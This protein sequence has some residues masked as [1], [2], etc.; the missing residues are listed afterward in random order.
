MNILLDAYFDCNYGDDIFIQGIASLFPAHKFYVFLEYY[1]E[2]I[3]QW[4]QS[5]PN[6]FPLPENAMFLEKG[7]FDAYL[8]VGGDVFPDGGNYEK[9]KRYIS[10]VKAVNGK[11]IF[12]GF[13]M[14]HSY[15]EETRKDL[16]DM[17]GE[18]DLIAPR[19]DAS[20]EILKEILGGREILSMADLA[21]ST[22]FLNPGADSENSANVANV[23]DS[24]N[25]A[26]VTNSAAASKKSILGISVRRPGNVTDE[27]MEGYIQGICDVI[28]TY[29]GTVR[30]YG[31]SDGVNTDTDLID[32]IMGRVKNPGRVE[33]IIYAGDI[34]GIVASME[35][36][37]LFIGTR[38]HA[39][40]TCIAK[41][42]P[43]IPVSYEVK[44]DHLFEE[45]SY[46]GTVVAFE[47]AA[48]LS[49]IIKNAQGKKYAEI[50]SCEEDT[51]AK[52][53]SKSKLILESVGA[54]LGIVNCEPVKK[55]GI[56][57]FDY[58]EAIYGKTQAVE[59]IHRQEESE[60]LAGYLKTIEELNAAQAEHFR[61]I[62]ELNKQNAEFNSL[63][64][65]LAGEKAE[66]EQTVAELKQ[67][68][69]E[70]EQTLA[71]LRARK[72]MDRVLNKEPEVPKPEG[73]GGGNNDGEQ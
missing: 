33:K 37:E 52:Y 24:S 62:D 8:C 19:D 5:I 23:T 22:E 7:L 30:L 57:A 44:T 32:E 41:K 61:M 10:A 49:K 71:A 67:T 64:A 70:L 73:N 29:T 2:K 42:I 40:L 35:E 54:L 17:L 26:S 53:A 4:A 16:R 72:L 38:F 36:C 47:N 59:E 55:E 13:N 18:A 60:A 50:F 25:T 34:E 14:F 65:K 15:G 66:L 39:I 28:D 21:L 27:V 63:A 51:V 6:V 9:R 58:T 45:I 68:V 20:A 56:G 43:F 46:R 48:E 11:V 12:V 69:A 3:V 1:P 31:L